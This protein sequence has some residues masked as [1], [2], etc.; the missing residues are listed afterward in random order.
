M[1][2]SAATV[3]RHLTNFA[4]GLAQDRSASLAEFIAPT[5]PTGLAHGQFKRYS[6]KNDFQVL[7]TSRAVGGTRKRIE[8]GATDPFFNCLPQGLETTI[9]DHE[10]DLAGEG[11]L[12]L[13]EAKIRNL[14]GAAVHNAHDVVHLPRAIPL[15]PIGAALVTIG[16]TD[17][18]T[19]PIILARLAANPLRPEAQ[20][21]AAL[22]TETLSTQPAQD[23][24]Q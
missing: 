12:N 11:L 19:E 4:S 15:R 16:I 24:D 5:V 8:F 13:Q 18:G 21:L 3:N 2:A 14:V 10:R 7:D 22:I 17:A 23:T 6:E 1:P 9:D 20:S